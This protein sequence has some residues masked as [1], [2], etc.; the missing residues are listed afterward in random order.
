MNPEVDIFLRKAKK[1]R[2]EMTLL[3][4]LVLECGLDEEMKWMH[5]CYTHNESNI[6]LIHGFKDYCALLFFKGVL[7]KDKKALLVQQTEN[8][9]D[10][11]QMRFTSSTEIEN[12][13]PDIKTYI[14]QAIEVEQKGLKVAFKKTADFAMPDEFRKELQTNNNLKTAFQNLTPGRQRGYLLYFAS[15]KQSKTRESRIQKY[16]PRIL[17]GYGLDD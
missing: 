16:I 4:S 10:R 5:P 11:R 14:R 13:S 17:E 7:L 12:L 9:Q 3:R 8:V 2:E 1:W 15:A 6:V